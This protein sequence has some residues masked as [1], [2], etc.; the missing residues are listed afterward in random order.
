M[1]RLVRTWILQKRQKRIPETCQ[2]KGKIFGLNVEEIY[3]RLYLFFSDHSLAKAKTT[4]KIVASCETSLV[5]LMQAVLRFLFSLE[6]KRR[7]RSSRC[8]TP[9]LSTP[10]TQS[11]AGVRDRSTIKKITIKMINFIFLILTETFCNKIFCL[12]WSWKPIS[13]IEWNYGVLGVISILN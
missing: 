4:F 3:L 1:I 2:P 12:S 6:L 11:Q 8:P 5:I 7:M 9:P 13:Y 10:I